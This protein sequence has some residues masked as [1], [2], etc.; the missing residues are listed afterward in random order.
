MVS[1]LSGGVHSAFASFATD[2][3]LKVRTPFTAAAL[4]SRRGRG[5]AS[6]I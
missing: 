3:E 6:G 1:V 4:P 5:K 2:P